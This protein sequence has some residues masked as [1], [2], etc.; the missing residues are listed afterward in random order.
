MKVLITDKDIFDVGVIKEV[1]G[2]I[3]YK[4]KMQQCVCSSGGRVHS[5]NACTCL[6]MSL[7]LVITRTKKMRLN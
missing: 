5:G 6:K 3:D 1:R 4:L 7:K 2:T